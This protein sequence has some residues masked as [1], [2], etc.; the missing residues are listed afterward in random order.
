TTPNSY[1]TTSG[2]FQQARP[3]TDYRLNS[4]HNHEAAASES[5]IARV[6]LLCGQLQT[7]ST[8]LRSLLSQLQSELASVK[9][10]IIE[11]QR[12]Q[13]VFATGI[14]TDQHDLNDNIIIQS[15][16]VKQYTS[17]PE[18]PEIY[19]GLRTHL[20]I[21]ST[22][23]FDP[24][25]I[26]IVRPIAPKSAKPHHSIYSLWAEKSVISIINYCDIYKF[27][28]CNYEYLFFKS[29]IKVLFDNTTV[30]HIKPPRKPNRVATES[31][32]SNLPEHSPF[33]VEHFSEPELTLSEEEQAFAEYQETAAREIG[34]IAATFEKLITDNTQIGHLQTDSAAKSYHQSESYPPEHPVIKGDAPGKQ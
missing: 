25:S 4:H 24:I 32:M 23:D 21:A 22:T 11:L 7:E 2:Q 29:Q 16:E 13:S 17:E 8:E 26:E 27:L 6:E 15:I 10:Q 20:G 12:S 9:A 31:V 1:S 34:N 19:N 3:R 18:L 33:E 30:T 5:R 28:Q 14:T